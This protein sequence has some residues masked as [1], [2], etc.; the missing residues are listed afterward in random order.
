M[1]GIE[2]TP[3]GRSGG[4]M[5]LWDKNLTVQIHSYSTDYIDV[6]I[7]GDE[8]SEGWRFTGFY[9]NPEVA[10]RKASW[11]RL[12]RLSQESTKPWL[13]SGDFNEVLFQHE[14]MGIARPSWQIQDFRNA[15]Q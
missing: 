5:L 13:C 4:L 6:D 11:E 3:R 8:V 7:Y 15:L 14:K 2:V 10:R 12:F 9:G 1:F